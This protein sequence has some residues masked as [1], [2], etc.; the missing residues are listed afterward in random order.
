VNRRD[1]VKLGG[2]AALELGAAK[3]LLSQM[4]PGMQSGAPVT[5]TTK[6]DNPIKTSPETACRIARPL[7]PVRARAFHAASYRAS[8]A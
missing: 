7:S 8:P 2:V 5:E 4:Q 3:L 1:F 6:A